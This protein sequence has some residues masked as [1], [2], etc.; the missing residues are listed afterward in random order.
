[1][2]IVRPWRYEA[3]GLGGGGYRLRGGG[4][5]N[6]T[7]PY[8]SFGR[9]VRPRRIAFEYKVSRDCRRRGYQRRF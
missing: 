2:T 4:E 3:L 6:F 8:L 7:G 5:M 1:M 9:L